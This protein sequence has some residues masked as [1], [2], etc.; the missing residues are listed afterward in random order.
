MWN[1]SQPAWADSLK[2]GASLIPNLPLEEEEA[3]R[4]VK[5]FNK[6]RLPDVPGQPSLGEAA[7]EWIRDRKSVV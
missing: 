4:A 5:M 7:G 3:S 2:A 1:F 6:L